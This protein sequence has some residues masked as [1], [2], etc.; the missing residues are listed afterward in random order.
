MRLKTGERA[1]NNIY[2][3]HILWSSSMFILLSLFFINFYW[4]IVALQCCVSFYCTAKWISY[5]MCHSLLF[6][7][8]PFSPKAWL[9]AFCM[10][11]PVRGIELQRKMKYSFCPWMNPIIPT[12]IFRSHHLTGQTSESSKEG[13]LLHPQFWG[14]LEGF[15]VQWCLPGIRSVQ[16]GL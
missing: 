16:E 7:P 4:S 12:G 1:Q 14:F 9:S 13:C 11:G 2:S 10:S 6:S 15:L 8:P 3:Q 5:N